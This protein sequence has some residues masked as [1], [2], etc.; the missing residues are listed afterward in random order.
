MDRTLAGSGWNPGLGLALLRIVV[1]IVF[2]AHGWP[3][4]AGGM[5][6]TAG[7]FGSLGIPAAGL[8]A[9]FI[10]LLETFG[11]ALLAVGLFVTP[12]AALFIAHMVTG[13]FLAHLSYGFYVIGPGAGGYE[14]NLLLAASALTLI[15]AGGG[16]WALQDRFRKEIVEA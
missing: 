3:K 8:A 1:G 5:E 16:R 2:I 4:L 12:L 10:A 11:G 15:L 13:I 7:Y 6:G 9:W 14:L